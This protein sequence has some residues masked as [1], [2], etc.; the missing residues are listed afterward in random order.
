MVSRV[1]PILEQCSKS[2]LR[3]TWI[4]RSI[5]KPTPSLKANMS[6][7]VEGKLVSGEV[8]FLSMQY[9]SGDQSKTEQV[10]IYC[11]IYRKNPK[12]V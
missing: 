9:G 4:L 7:C 2:G 8:C 5:T 11:Y 12:G 3:K 1:E 10:R 6:K